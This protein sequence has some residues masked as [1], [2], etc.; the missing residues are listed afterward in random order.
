[1]KHVPEH[2]GTEKRHFIAFSD[3]ELDFLVKTMVTV[4]EAFPKFRQTP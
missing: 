2:S 3:A 4:P 1:L